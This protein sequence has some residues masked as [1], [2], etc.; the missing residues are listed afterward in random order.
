MD[1]SR[2]VLGTVQFGLDYG[3]N[4]TAG[5]PDVATVQR[6][7]N[8]ASDNG[9]EILDT[10]SAYGDSETLLGELDAASR[11]QFVS[12]LAAGEEPSH[13]LDA[14]LGRLRTE[15]LYAFILHDASEIRADPARWEDMLT[16]RDTGKTR[17][18]GLSVYH[19]SEIDFMFANGLE[20]DLVQLPWSVYDQRF[21]SLLSPLA[22]AGIEVHARSIFLQGL[23]FRGAADLPP[24]FSTIVERQTTL[25]RLA[26]RYGMPLAT[27]LLGFGLGQPGIDRVVVGV[28]N[29]T[30]LLSDLEALRRSP[31]NASIRAELESLE[32]NDNA[33]VLP[34]LWH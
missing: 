14:A 27:L 4:N 26:E 24:T 7:L 9:I 21:K 23:L 25:H 13:G 20:F 15:S 32:V 2:L 10:A 34:T 12:K 8:A 30:Q 17:R 19:P 3:I 31:H 1:A 16:I 11:F 33:I 22:D 18:I 29:E 28:D 6:I 5:R